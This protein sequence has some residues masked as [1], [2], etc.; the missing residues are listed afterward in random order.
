MIKKYWK[1]L[2][3]TSIVNLL[4]MVMGLML[5]EQ[6]PEQ[7]PM[8]WNMAGEVDGWTGKTFAVFG[9][10][11]LMAALEWVCVFATSTDPK[12]KDVHGKMMHLMLWVIPAVS[13]VLHGCV[14][15]A[16]LGR[17]V[18]ISLIVPM[19]LGLLFMCI[20]NYMPKCR[21][22]YTIGIKLPWTL[23]SE[24]NWNRTHRLGGFVWTV[25]GF[26]M[27]ISGF[28]GSFWLVIASAAAMVAVPVVYS[29]LL[30]R[31]GV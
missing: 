30:Y 5:W 8:H 17:E 15:A 11:L 23:N 7:M 6:L 25:G 18:E 21:Q 29:Y 31:K 22:S 27:L 3:V 13:L 20:G 24:E 16:A 4:P 2:V 14:Y 28:L 9:M 19:L 10:P 26:L 12:N 1:T